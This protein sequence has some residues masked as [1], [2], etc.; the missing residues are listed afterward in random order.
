MESIQITLDIPETFSRDCQTYGLCEAEILQL[1]INHIYA[2]CAIVGGN[3]PLLI[4]KTTKVFRD[5]LKTGK[6]APITESKRALVM[7]TTQTIVAMTITKV[8]PWSPKAYSQL[9]NN[10]YTELVLINNSKGQYGNAF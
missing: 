8:L 3:E 9:I 7:A 1:F 10:A 4:T 6:S 5:F 2:L